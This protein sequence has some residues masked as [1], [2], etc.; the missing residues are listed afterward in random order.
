MMNAISRNNT[1][2]PAI[3]VVEDFEPLRFSV[4]TWLKYR[5]PGCVVQGVASA[6]E[7]LEHVRAFSP[8][9]VLMDINLPGING[10]EAT[11]RMKEQAPE[12][13]VVILTTHDTPH[14]RL[15][16]ATA[17]AKAYVA[18]HEMET[19]LEAAIKSLLGSRARTSS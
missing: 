3:L 16:A 13:A 4:V 1:K 14:H 9:I 18:K 6:E 11:C 8:E 10:L 5:F 17:G 7:A 12:T 19:H 15:A 2:P